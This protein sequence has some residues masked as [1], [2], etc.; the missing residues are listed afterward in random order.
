MVLDRISIIDGKILL[1]CFGSQGRRDWTCDS[2]ED[3]VDE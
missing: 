1:G 2:V 3:V